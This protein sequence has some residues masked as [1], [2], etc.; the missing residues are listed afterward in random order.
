MYP[1]AVE[2]AGLHSELNF[3]CRGMPHLSS[4]NAASHRAGPHF[5]D[6]L[7]GW[8]DALARQGQSKAALAKYDDAL[9]YAPNWKELKETRQAV[10]K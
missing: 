3:C 2:G 5:A 1:H 9:Q 7:K 4:K 10:A 6:A 8:G